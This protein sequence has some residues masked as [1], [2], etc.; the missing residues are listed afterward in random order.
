MPE[1]VQES[2]PLK[3]FFFTALSTLKGIVSYMLSEAEIP[4]GIIGVDLP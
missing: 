1:T 3:Q 4:K 2:S